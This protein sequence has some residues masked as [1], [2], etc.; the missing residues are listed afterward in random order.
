[1]RFTSSTIIIREPDYILQLDYFIITIIV[2]T[3]S[4]ACGYTNSPCQISLW[5]E[6]GAPEE[7]P[8][9]SAEGLLTL[10]T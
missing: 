6:T 10:F 5:E 8:R 4:T 2:I 7:N 3:F 1:M 9:L